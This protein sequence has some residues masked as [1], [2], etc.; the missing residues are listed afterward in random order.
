[1]Q[2]DSRYVEEIVQYKDMIF[3]GIPLNHR[4]YF[5]L[6]RSIITEVAQDVIPQ[7]DWSYETQKIFL[8]A[9]GKLS[10]EQWT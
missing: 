9:S 8:V 2:L 3:Y 4:N 1:M 5:E 10:L 7:S 6:K